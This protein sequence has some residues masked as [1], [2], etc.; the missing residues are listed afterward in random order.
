MVHAHVVRHRRLRLRPC[1]D[2]GNR[3]GWDPAGA[4]DAAPAAPLCVLATSTAH[5][6]L[7]VASARS[8]PHRF[9]SLR[10]VLSAFQSVSFASR[11][12]CPADF[13]V[14][15]FKARWRITF[16]VRGCAT[17]TTACATSS[18]RVPGQKL[19]RT[20]RAFSSALQRRRDR[21]FAEKSE[22]SP[23]DRSQS[24]AEP[25]SESCIRWPSS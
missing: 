16:G 23:L 19:S 12:L 24:P 8:A 15:H 2:C 4:I 10:T 5:A 1:Q 21:R 13:N 3:G 18:T 6:G 11:S 14:S 22:P 7:A 20:I 25:R 17:P 9:D